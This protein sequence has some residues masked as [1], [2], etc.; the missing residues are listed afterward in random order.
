MHLETFLIRSGKIGRSS[1]SSL[2]LQQPVPLSCYLTNLLHVP[3]DG[4]DASFLM[5]TVDLRAEHAGS[6]L[7]FHSG[8]IDRVPKDLETPWFNNNIIEHLI[9]KA[10]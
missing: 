3:I 8:F 1:E 10:K 2:N 6:G 5:L 7:P 4:L 9:S